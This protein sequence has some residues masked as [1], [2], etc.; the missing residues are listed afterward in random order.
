MKSLLASVFLLA[1]RLL[2]SSGPNFQ[3]I[4]DDFQCFD[5]PKRNYFQNDQ[6]T[7]ITDLPQV[8]IMMCGYES[9]CALEFAAYLF[10]REKLGMNVTFYPTLDYDNIWSGDLWDNWANSAYPRNY[11]AWLADD[12]M[13]LNF[14]FWPTQLMVTDGDGEETFNGETEFILPGLIDFGG[15][16]GA[17]GEES[18]WVPKYW[19]DTYTDAFIPHSLKTSEE[20]RGQLMNASSAANNVDGTDYIGYYN[21]S[22]GWEMTNVT[23]E[24]L[25][26]WSM[27]NV[28]TA[29]A[30]DW[31]TYDDPIVWGSKPSYFMSA[32]ANDLTKTFPSGG[33]NVS[34]VTTGSEASL[35][36]L[37][38]DLY[39]QRLPFLA[40]IYTLDVNFGRVDEASGELQ[41]FE[42]LVYPRNPDQSAYDP[43]FLAKSCQYHVA[44]I[45]KAANPLLK[46]R[47]PE[48]AEFFNVY[49]MG[50]S[51]IN[52]LVS[53]YLA[54]ENSNMTSTE[55]WLNA[56]CSWMKDSASHSTWNI[57]SWDIE[58]ERIRCTSGCGI[59]GKGGSCNYFTGQC[60][61]DY[62][63]IFADTNCTES[64]PG[65]VGPYVNGSSGEYVF[66]FCSGHGVC[67]TITRQCSCSD[68]YGDSGCS[69]KY[70][71][72]TYVGLTVIITAFS[73]ILAIVGVLCIVWLR[74]SQ[75]YKTVKA[76]SV[77][78]TTLMTVGIIFLV[79]SNIALAFPQ[80]SASC[81]A[82]QWLFGMG[83]VLAIMSPLLKAYRVSRV[84]HGGKML[85]AVKITDAMLMATLI[86]SA[87]L[88]MIL[89]IAY[90]VSHEIFGGTTIYYNH[91]ELRSEIQCNSSTITQYLSMGSYAYFFVILCALTYYSWGTRRALSVFKESTCA[92]F[93]SFLSLLC[94][95]I[96]VVFYMATQ[97]PAFRVAVQSFAI[98]I[99]VVGVLTL[100]YGTR[101]YAFYNEP[102]NRNV[103]DARAAS[104]ASTTSKASVMKPGPNAAA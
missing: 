19:V 25:N 3:E 71:E 39:S 44:P 35:A 14:E 23:N 82:W 61:C 24:T 70:E 41:Q 84:F 103:T 50:T 76:L 101:I 86:K 87:V 91:E 12:K 66:D 36:A 6:E 2:S 95:L 28:F 1:P 4:L 65:L 29:P 67:D 53:N 73:G 38:A 16:V 78:M 49:S 93:S 92:Y 37:V 54:L 15:F 57:S 58:I 45:M 10:M 59:D 13:D 63:E 22:L 9:Q 72:Y 62:D 74:M 64:C 55:K 75:E 104:N 8:R 77:N 51:Q 27:N 90:S 97:D 40:N 18:I 32:Y 21:A 79:S 43:C 83:G 69:T 11:F 88:E 17:Y 5:E 98:I 34:F 81:I 60:E 48:A 96:T 99:V 20:Y 26:T 7:E 102:E 30:F 68:G 42:K 46:T 33:M 94:T 52:L 100:F 80:N 89:C 47:F 31:P 56:T 85:R